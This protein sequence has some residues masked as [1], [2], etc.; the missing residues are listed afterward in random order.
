MRDDD[1]QRRTRGQED[2]RQNR[3]R[4]FRV[5]FNDEDD[6]DDSVSQGPRSA[7]G[8]PDVLHSYSSPQTRKAMVE[9]E[10]RAQKA[11][12]KALRERSREKGRKNRH[13]CER[14][15][16]AR[17]VRAENGYGLRGD[18]QLSANKQ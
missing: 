4:Q 14:I 13:A 3:A 9:S 5:E 1:N 17:H 7:A 16:S 18:Y 12:E 15:L 6:M 11:Q 8:E 10:R 2:Q